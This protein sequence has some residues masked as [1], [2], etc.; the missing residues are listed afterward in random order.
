MPGKPYSIGSGLYDPPD[1][2]AP[3]DLE[4]GLMGQPC[5]EIRRFLPVLPL[6]LTPPGMSHASSLLRAGQTDI[7]SMRIPA[8]QS[9]ALTSLRGTADLSYRDRIPNRSFR[10]EVETNDTAASAWQV[11][12]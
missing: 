8:S 11:T 5:P 10:S 1:H 4:K 12:I 9:T 2:Q 7:R 3:G 6:I